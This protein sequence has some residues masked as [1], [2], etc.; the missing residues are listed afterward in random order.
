MVTCFEAYP[1]EEINKVVTD[2]GTVNLKEP[3]APVLVP[4][5]VP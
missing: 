3:S 4:I 1:T 2:E 5:V